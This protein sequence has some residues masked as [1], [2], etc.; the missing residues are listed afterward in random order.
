MAIAA[1]IFARLRT[2]DASAISRSTS[3][4]PNA[5]TTL[6]IEPANA[7]R[8]P[9]RLRRIVIQDSPDWNASRHSFSYSAARIAHRAA[10]LVVVVGDVLGRGHAPPAAQPPVG[11]FSQRVAHAAAGYRLRPGM[12]FSRLG[13]GE[14]LAV[15]GGL[16]LALSLFLPWYATNPDNR[17]A[18]D[19][20]R[21]RLA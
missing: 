13:R 4:S 5:A 6:G 15:L 7:A 1:S 11:S 16:L 3:C 10:P 20:R 17:N 19:R 2:I 14:Y 8:N 12:N 18:D 9:S 21:P